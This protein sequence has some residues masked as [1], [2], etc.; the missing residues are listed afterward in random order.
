M[1]NDYL[2]RHYQEIL[3]KVKGV[4]R[5]HHLTEDLL[6]DC[7]LSFLEKGNDYI[8]QVLRDD[9]V[10]HYL[11]RMV[12]IQFNSKTSPFYTQ[13]RKLSRKTDDIDKYE[14]EEQPREKKVDSKKLADDV[15]IYIGNLPL[16]QRTYAQRFYFDNVS[17][18]NM[19]KEYGINRIH[20][21][22]G[23]NT[24]QNN[25]KLMFNKN[26]YKTE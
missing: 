17:Q 12:H 19:S 3:N 4:T 14:I 22:R 13:Y 6:Q 21:A 10:Q 7:I 18:R 15:K 24:V 20:I 9:K 1:I 26:D 11:V 23:I 8:S 5:N 25:I 2:Q 16:E